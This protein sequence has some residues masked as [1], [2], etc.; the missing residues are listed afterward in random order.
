MSDEPV[1]GLQPD[2][3]LS[4][5]EAQSR[6][7]FLVGLGRWS[8]VVIGAAVFGGL[9]AG[10]TQAEAAWINRRGG[11]INGVGGGGAGWI[12]RRGGGGGSWINRR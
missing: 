9:A 1:G 12:N 2:A 7:A 4:D 10:T 6:R 11:W 3:A 8:K 5:P